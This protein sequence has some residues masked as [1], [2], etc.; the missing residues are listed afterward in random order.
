M[1]KATSVF[2]EQSYPD[3][4]CQTTGLG[5]GITRRKSNIPNIQ[6]CLNIS[7]GHESGARMALMLLLLP[8]L[9]FLHILDPD[10]QFCD[11]LRPSP[12]LFWCRLDDASL[13]FSPGL[14]RSFSDIR[15]IL[16][17]YRVML[18]L[19]FATVIGLLALRTLS[20]QGDYYLE[21]NSVHLARLAA[22]PP[23]SS[24]IENLYIEGST[25]HSD[26]VAKASPD[27]MNCILDI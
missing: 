10:S 7:T 21:S 22:I 19:S 2:G 4:S 11:R 17:S 16:F 6:A 14:H 24:L 8:R 13:T 27:C 26:T 15:M 3:S 1:Y 18:L 12:L 5:L 25:I 23:R 9:K 20:F